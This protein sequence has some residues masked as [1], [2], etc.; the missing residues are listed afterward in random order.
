[1]VK[2]PLVSVIIPTFRSGSTLEKCLA[3]IKNQ[4]KANVEIITVDEFSRD[5]TPAIARKYGKFYQIKGERSVARNFGASKA[6]GAYLLF[7]DSDMVLDPNIVSSSIKTSQFKKAVVIPEVSIGTGFWSECRILERKCYFGNDA[8]EAARFFPRKMFQSLGGYDEAMAGV[9]DWDIHQRTLKKQFPVARISETV[10]HNE[11]NIRLFK[12]LK[13][14]FYY[15]QVFDKY[16]KR[17]PQAF[18]NAFFR[19]SF[20][21]NMHVFLG[22]PVHTVGILFMKGLE[23]IA[24][25]LGMVQGI[26]YGYDAKKHY[27]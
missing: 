19:T 14:K 24:I 21:K 6:R 5:L 23:G 9:E 1:M 13:K 3:S 8:V 7:I 16:R 4:K 25:L 26:L 17:H 20:F 27:R 11:G 12:V 10:V 18:R 2:H 15:G 22:D